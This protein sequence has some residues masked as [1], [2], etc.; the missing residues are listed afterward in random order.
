MAEV[1]TLPKRLVDLNPRWASGAFDGVERRGIALNFD[2]PCQD[3]ACAWGGVISV[4]IAN[5]IDGLP[6]PPQGAPRTLW[7]RTGDSFETLS[8]DPSI[9]AVGHWHGWLTNGM[10]VSV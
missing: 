1:K 5:P 6:S 3:E 10:L 4:W 2:C 8:L 7:S 9:H